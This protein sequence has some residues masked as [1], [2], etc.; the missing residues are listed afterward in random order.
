M[1]GVFAPLELKR[2]LAVSEDSYARELRLCG[3]KP[4][5]GIHI[6]SGCDIRDSGGMANLVLSTTWHTC[7]VQQ[8]C[9]EHIPGGWR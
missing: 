8:I 7:Q 3:R 2:G 6:Y 9:M 1:T 4:E 5:E